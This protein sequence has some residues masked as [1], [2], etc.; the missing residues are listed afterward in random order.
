MNSSK[1]A[2]LFQKSIMV[3]GMFFAVF[4]IVSGVSKLAYADGS[5]EDYLHAL[6]NGDKFSQ[7][8]QYDQAIEAY[9]KAIEIA[10]KKP[11]GYCGRG[12]VYSIQKKYEQALKDLNMAITIDPENADAYAQRSVVYTCKGA[13]TKAMKDF[14]LFF[15]YAKPNNPMIIPLKR[16]ILAN[17]YSITYDETATKLLRFAVDHNDFAQ[18][19]QA[20]GMGAD[21][22]SRAF[23]VAIEKRDPE[24]VQYFINNG[25]DV[26]L[27]DDDWTPLRS[28]IIRK[29]IE[30]ATLLINAGAHQNFCNNYGNNLIYDVSDSDAPENLET[31]K[32][33]LA[34]G[35][36]VNKANNDGSTA[37]MQACKNG[38][39]KMARLLLDNGANPNVSN[40][41]GQRAV[42]FAIQSGNRDL[43]NLLLSVT[44]R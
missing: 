33:L 16:Y 11:Y 7:S 15:K 5:D 37:L 12:T 42:D 36:D 28:A 41:N 22:N 10:P 27:K 29:R 20:F 26:N 18:V 30:I 35:V 34:N 14:D 38:C 21:P 44:N 40:R 17:G 13:R 43:M 31:V 9:T 24:M 39:I 2:A 23:W 6:Q 1:I 3:I 19:K 32:F 4:M 25:A 8:N